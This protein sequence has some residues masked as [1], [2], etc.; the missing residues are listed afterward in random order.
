MSVY[1]HHS[2]VIILPRPK[3]TFLSSTRHL[4]ISYMYS[5]SK[6]EARVGHCKASWMGLFLSFFFFLLRRL[7]SNTR[8][9]STPLSSIRCRQYLFQ[10]PVQFLIGKRGIFLTLFSH[11]AIFT[12]DSSLTF[13]IVMSCCLLPLF[14]L[15]WSGVAKV[16]WLHWFHHFPTRHFLPKSVKTYLVFFESTRFDS[17][18]F[19]PRAT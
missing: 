10:G 7:L 13:L 15:G 9:F 6:N 3:V 18:H 16:S 19:E 11:H 14:V 12:N 1:Y 4:L 5:T 8:L 2:H 17:S